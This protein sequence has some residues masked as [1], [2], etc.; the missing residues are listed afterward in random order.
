MQILKR[1]VGDLSRQPTTEPA[2]DTLWKSPN[3]PVGGFAYFGVL[4]PGGRLGLLPWRG[5]SYVDVGS[6][7]NAWDR[8]PKRNKRHAQASESIHYRA[9]FCAV[10]TQSHVDAITVVES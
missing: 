7:R 2:H 10:R 3:R 1:Q 5:F 6:C 9:T 8:S 4:P